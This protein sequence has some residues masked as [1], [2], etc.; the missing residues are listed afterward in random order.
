MAQYGSRKR[1]SR[2]RRLNLSDASTGDPNETERQ[3]PATV[4]EANE[5]RTVRQAIMTQL[6]R[7]VADE[8]AA[9]GTSLDGTLLAA[10]R[11]GTL[12]RLRALITDPEAEFNKTRNKLY[13]SRDF[14]SINLVVFRNA[15]AIGVGT[16][17]VEEVARR[18][19]IRSGMSGNFRARGLKGFAGCK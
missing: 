2:K 5:R 14:G 15:M 4:I 6:M 13:V 16:V 7:D 11:S 12:P 3:P 9:S 10:Y 1:G 8:I 17:D 19:V 18:V